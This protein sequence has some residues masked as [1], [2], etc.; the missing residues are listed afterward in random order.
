MGTT[1]SQIRQM[2]TRVVLRGWDPISVENPAHPGT[3]DV[4]FA[5]GWLELKAIGRW[6]ARPDTIVRVDHFTPQQR[7]W[8]TRRWRCDRRAWVLMRVGGWQDTRSTWLLFAGD[9]AAEHLGKVPRAQ[10]L[11]VALAAW[12]PKLDVP[13]FR[14][15][16]APASSTAATE[17]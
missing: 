13:A 3:P 9:V 12:S 16:V 15:L 10:L 17:G 11:E 2:I 4:N 5:G 1:E 8:L 14:A 6:P 7:V